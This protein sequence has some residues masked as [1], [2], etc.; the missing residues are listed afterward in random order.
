MRTLALVLLVAALV[1]FAVLHGGTSEPAAPATASAVDLSSAPAAP[2]TLEASTTNVESKSRR[3]AAASRTE[4]SLSTHTSPASTP[5]PPD[6]CE[7]RGR[8]V[9]TGGAAARVVHLRLDGWA[10][11][12]ERER[13]HGLPSAW[14]D[15]Q[16]TSAEDGTFAL[17]FDPPGAFTFRLDARLAGYAG[18][19]W[20]WYEL[21]RGAI[22]ELGTIELPRAG[23]VRARIVDTQGRLLSRGWQI[24]AENVAFG[25]GEDRQSLRVSASPF[26]KKGEALLEGLHA[27]AVVLSAHSELA[28]WI[29]G[30]TVEVRAG[31][32]TRADVVYTGPDLGARV[33]VT[34]FVDRFPFDD[35]VQEILL[36][37]PDFETRRVRR[38]ANSTQTYCFDDVPPGVY[39]LE[40]RDPRYEPWSKAKVRPGANVDAY[41]KGNAAVVLELV[42]ASGAPVRDVTVDVRFDGVNFSPN[43]FPLVRAGKRLP[44]DG[45]LDRLLP[46]DQTLFVSATG[47]PRLEIPVPALAPFETRALRAVLARGARVSGRVVSAELAAPVAGVRVRIAAERTANAP[48]DAPDD[49]HETTSAADGRFAFENIAPGTQ[50]VRACRALAVGEARVT[51]DERATD[52]EVEIVLPESGWIAGKFLAPP[53]AIFAEFSVRVLPFTVENGID[54][55]LIQAIDPSPNDLAQP[56]AADGTFVTRALPCG[57]VRVDLLLRG[58]DDEIFEVLS[59]PQI[60]AGHATVHPGETRAEFDVR[61]SFPG[62][63]VVRVRVDGAPAAHADVAFR[64]VGSWRSGAATLAADGAGRVA[65]LVPGTYALE[66]RGADRSWVGSTGA[67]Y[68]LTSGATIEVALDVQR[69]RGSLRVLDV[70]TG[71]PLANAELDIAP[72]ST[73]FGFAARMRTGPRGEL[74]LALPAGEY[75]VRAVVNEEASWLRSG[76]ILTWPPSESEPI[77]VRVDRSPRARR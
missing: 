57:P 16:A 32:E 25:L 66:V 61:R 60:E 6:V 70:A 53:G 41:L 28:N 44:A 73:E 62:A 48:W 51:V 42:D 58:V 26:G 55:K 36:S 9:L 17:R 74:Q 20:Q 11:N 72:A 8:F 22:V 52:A 29:D 10:A 50:L 38:V 1:L 37:A 12:D 77:E 3:A 31:E 15:L 49:V 23:S 14:R 63:I 68:A 54:G 46:R 30:P 56:I 71:E 39:A 4:T 40:V 18:A 24:Y 65:P 13:M 35:D 43:V 59:A 75:R 33:T 45:R 2:A 21:A 47:Y 7:I 76:A 34:T 19:T 27:G 69:T 5:L 67:A 64:D